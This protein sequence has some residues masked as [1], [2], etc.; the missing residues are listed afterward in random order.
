MTK[1][2]TSGYGQLMMEDESEKNGGI[3]LL[4]FGIGNAKV[5]PMSGHHVLLNVITIH[6]FCRRG[7]RAA[8]HTPA[9]TLD[10][11]TRQSNVEICL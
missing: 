3:P 2:K 11:R 10:K 8:A 4:E 7:K 9:L 1:D 5:A 6:L